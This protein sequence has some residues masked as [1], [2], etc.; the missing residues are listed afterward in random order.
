MRKSNKPEPSPHRHEIFV[1]AERKA[2]GVRP[3]KEVQSNLDNQ[4]LVIQE[5]LKT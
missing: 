1:S 4:K 2:K 3:T 5:N